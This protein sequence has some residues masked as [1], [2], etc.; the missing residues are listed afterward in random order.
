MKKIILILIVL[1]T[2]FGFSQ[3]EF[4]TDVEVD[5][6]VTAVSF[7]GDGQGITINA[8]GFDGNL[9]TSDDTLQEIAQ[10]LDDLDIGGD[11]TGLYAS[12]TNANTLSGQNTFTHALNYFGNP[13][14][15]HLRLYGDNGFFEAHSSGGDWSSLRPTMIVFNNGTSAFFKPNPSPT[16]TNYDVLMP[17]APGTTATEEWV[18]AQGYGSGSFDPSSNQT[19][20]GDWNFTKDLLMAASTKIDFGNSG[21]IEGLGNAGA[22]D[23]ALPLG[24]A[25]TLY[26]PIGSY[27]SQTDIDTFA[28]LDA[29]VADKP[30]VNS[31]EAQ[32]FTNT[33][34]FDTGTTSPNIIANNATASDGIELYNTGAGSNLYAS[35]NSSSAS[36]SGMWIYNNNLGIG[37]DM[38]NIGAGTGQK[39]TNG[40]SSTG[41]ALEIN[42]LTSSTG[43]LF[44]GKNNGT[45]TYTLDKEGNVVANTINSVAITNSGSATKYLNEQGGYTTPAG[46]GATNPNI[47]IPTAASD[48]TSPNIANQNK[49]WELQTTID[50]GGAVV[51][52][53]TY[54]ITFKDGGGQVTNFTS[55]DL[56]AFQV[57]DGENAVLFDQ[58]G[59]ITG[60]VN[61]ITYVRWFGLNANADLVSG[62]TLNGA[63]SDHIA[64]Q[65]AFSATSNNNG[66]VSFPAG[67]F[68]LQGDG[69]N[70]QYAF[71]NT[72]Y[73]NDGVPVSPDSQNRFQGE[74]QDFFFGEEGSTNNN[75]NNLRILGNDVTILSHPDNPFT[76]SNAGFM[77]Y[78]CNN[79][80][81][82]NI[83]Y[84]G[85]NIQ[86]DPYIGDT[87]PY[88]RQHSF[89]FFG[90]TNPVLKNVVVT[91]SMMDG[92]Y[93]GSDSG[94]QGAG[95]GGM[96][97]NCKSLNSYRQGLSGVSHSEMTCIKSVFSFTG[98]NI[99]LVDGRYLTTSPSAGVDLE[100]GGT[101]TA[102]N[103]RGQFNWVFDGCRFESNFG[104]GLSIHWGSRYAIII[105]CVFVDDELFEPQDS[106]EETTGNNT[107]SNNTF[108]NS[109]VALEAGGAHF[110]YNN[111]FF[112]DGINEG[113]GAVIGGAAGA[114]TKNLAPVTLK[115]IDTGGY[116]ELGWVRNT[117]VSNNYIY[118]DA[119]SS[120]FPSSGTEVIIG[121]TQVN[122]DQAIYEGNVY[123]NAIGVKSDGTS[124]TL[125]SV[126]TG[127]DNVYS[128]K[129]NKMLLTSAATSKYSS[130]GRVDYTSTDRFKDNK[131]DISY[132]LFGQ[133]PIGTVYHGGLSGTT[134]ERP[135]EDGSPYDSIYDGATYYDETLNQIVFWNGS[136][137]T[138]F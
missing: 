22:S 104:S 21:R 57:L 59:T 113:S 58:S 24:Q 120:N 62:G 26:Q 6:S 101:G 67:A 82:E 87:N 36:S 19:I 105:N 46:G 11:H 106:V 66:T 90:C 69:T 126:G 31:E 61:G 27:L 48:F 107:Y 83:N 102:P 70:P 45:N 53:S 55:I 54:N 133:F 130:Y 41:N 18:I 29:I 114:V 9:T 135:V 110:I 131:V 51:D 35:N 96:M 71:T 118:V 73:L 79:I 112:D 63:L 132:T 60:Q 16:G 3:K 32:T 123:T 14:S 103:V 124:A 68:L 111:F 40:N 23:E 108:Y 30:L 77:F 93:F 1:S 72:P 80:Y 137:W 33:Q 78:N 12:L 121:R 89:G 92:F 13:A 49:I 15:T 34:T 50:L 95:F 99:S 75:W 56:G 38:S 84:D 42:G 128:I 91:N 138:A 97:I 136:A 7:L 86:R 25:N 43:Y 98:K 5:G 100:A 88:N 39:I 4:K 85:N 134:A 117:I 52:L 17:P 119:A 127:G 122:V 44:V 37:L 125:I 74:R 20:T 76:A 115:L 65:N 28:E 2:T 10:K 8:S 64:I 109:T 116:T 94:G 129:N 47:F 81:I